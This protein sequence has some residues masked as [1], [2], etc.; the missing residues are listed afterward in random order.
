MKKFVS[1]FM[2]AVLCL[3]LVACGDKKID[4]VKATDSEKQTVINAA[5]KFFES[6]VF[7]KGAALH[8]EL[9]GEAAELPEL[10]SAYTLKYD[11]VEGYNVDLVLCNVKVWVTM[12]KNGE[13]IAFDKVQFIVDNKTGTVYDSVNYEDAKNNFNGTISSEEDVMI[14]FLN[15]GILYEGGDGYFWCDAETSTRFKG[16]DLKEINKAVLEAIGK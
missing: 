12:E 15:H 3:G 8:E 2:A 11:D 10:L 6:D 13:Y 4:T 16:S 5:V 14:M 9:S 1:L 7:V